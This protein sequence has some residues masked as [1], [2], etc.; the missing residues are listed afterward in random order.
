M[1]LQPVA[2]VVTDPPNHPLRPAPIRSTLAKISTSSSSPMLIIN[3]TVLLSQNSI[4]PAPAAE[5]TLLTTRLVQV[6]CRGPRGPRRA[7]AVQIA[8]SLHRQIAPPQQRT[9]SSRMGARTLTG[10]RRPAASS[11]GS[12]EH[13]QSLATSA[14]QAPRRPTRTQSSC[15]RFTMARR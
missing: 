1:A 4:A 6:A 7:H 14:E 11:S 3:R 12:L 2:Q 5:D 13:I 15:L 9:S 8:S 10:H